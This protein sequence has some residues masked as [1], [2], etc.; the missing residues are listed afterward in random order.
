MAVPRS[1]SRRSDPPQTPSSISMSP[2]QRNPTDPH[3]HPGSRHYNVLPRTYSHNHPDGIKGAEA[4]ALAVYLA[5][6]G[7][8]KGYIR[9]RMSEYYPKLKSKYF[10]DNNG[11]D[12]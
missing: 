9:E 11:F 7:K 5:R 3:S 2:S 8:D 1:D 12:N 6:T 10:F 4:V